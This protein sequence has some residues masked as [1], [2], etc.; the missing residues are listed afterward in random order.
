MSGPRKCAAARRAEHLKVRLTADERARVVAAAGER[1]QSVS[2]YVRECLGHSWGEL[3]PPASPFAASDEAQEPEA[4][5]P[6][7][8]R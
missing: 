7:G 8:A 4:A 5:A 1:G 2:E 3:T 6:D